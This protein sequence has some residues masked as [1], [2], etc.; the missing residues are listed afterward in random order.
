M[1]KNKLPEFDR[2]E[3]RRPFRI[4]IVTDNSK[5]RW[6]V[7]FDFQLGGHMVETFDSAAELAPSLTFHTPG[8]AVVDVGC[9]AAD[10]MRRIRADG[11]PL[12]A[13]LLANPANTRLA[14]TACRRG[15]AAE[16]MLSSSPLLG[17]DAVAAARRE[18]CAR[19]ELH[20][21]LSLV[22]NNQ[23]V[24]V[25]PQLL[26]RCKQ[27]LRHERT[28]MRFIAMGVDDYTTSQRL[29]MTKAQ[30]TSLRGRI[31]E[32]VGAHSIPSLIRHWISCQAKGRR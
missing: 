12:V 6:R 19:F 4:L 7:S 10:L 14:I 32:K 13:C 28:A 3:A 18:Y 30:F 1:Q 11:L 2:R 22:L 29:Q 17:F 24:G 31:R 20:E 15:L 5:H 27:L 16:W 23:V 26:S 8:I 21:D 9:G 25:D